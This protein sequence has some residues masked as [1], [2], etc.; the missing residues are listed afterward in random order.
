MMVPRD[1]IY[2]MPDERAYIIRTWKVSSMY[3]AGCCSGKMSLGI[4]VV[5]N[6]HDAYEAYKY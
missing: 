3:Q 2:I 5:G 6:S 4:N 1:S